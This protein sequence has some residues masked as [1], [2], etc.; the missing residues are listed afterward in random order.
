MRRKVKHVAD[1]FFRPAVLK[2]IPVSQL[3]AGMHVHELCGPWLDHPFWR[4]RFLL[5]QASDVARLVEGGVK[6]VWIDVS[7]G[8][9]VAPATADDP[10]SDTAH[11]HADRQSGGERAH[12]D[13]VSGRARTA[14]AAELDRAARL[15]HD[16][17]GAVI[18]MFTEA[19][20][21]KA[22]DTKGARVLVDE[23]DASIARHP[24]ALV[25]LARLKTADDY[26]FMHSIA[27]CGLMI[28]L[29]RR[30]QFEPRQLQ[31]AGLAG[32]L[33]DMG[34]ALVPSAMLN[35]PGRLTAAEFAVMKTHP[36]L[37]H[38]M[39]IE[40]GTAGEAA[41]DVCLHH[42]ERVD[43]SGYPYRLAGGAISL[44]ARMGAIC[45]VYDAITS[46]RPYK[47]GWN[48][49][50]SIRRMAEWTGG[51][52]DARVFHAFVKSIGIYPVGSLVRMATG[53]LG[54]V[55]EQNE[56]ALTSPKVRL[57]FSTR[58][59]T[60]ILPEVIDLARKGEAD[61][62]VTREDPRT[63][64]FHDIDTLWAGDNASRPRP[65]RT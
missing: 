15:C 1:L 7:K 12:P 4:T 27:V 44:Y 36:A 63:W 23:I 16:A 34:K 11:E 14:M 52:F 19:R 59:D 31:D 48:P 51:Q 58:S 3:R 13:R 50:E 54:V 45:D 25:S 21:G 47:A 35:K 57:F 8:L 46:N 65:T 20:M 62:I 28:S 39:L 43:G 56:A 22:I 29:G 42:H 33:H 17:R 55:I 37:G 26:T 53:R 10:P 24:D 32:L 9:D 30:L 6:E 60:R 18:A 38:R 41:L 40:A 2:R 49:A 61:R 5:K 64:N